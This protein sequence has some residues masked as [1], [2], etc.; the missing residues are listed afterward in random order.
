M[1]QR[2]YATIDKL[3]HKGLMTHE[4]NGGRTHLTPS[5]HPKRR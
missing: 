4:L 3:L 5:I 2:V 1:L